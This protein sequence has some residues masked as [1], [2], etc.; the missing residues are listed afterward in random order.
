[1]VNWHDGILYSENEL[2]LLI[3]W[4]LETRRWQ[5]MQKPFANVAKTIQL[6]YFKSSQM[7][8]SNIL[9]S[10]CHSLQASS[11]RVCVCA[12]I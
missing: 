10:Y 11:L 7:S 2:L 3:F 12:P 5:P 6:T 9:K 1:M 4:T 8:F